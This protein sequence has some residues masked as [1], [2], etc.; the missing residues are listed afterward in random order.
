M[1]ENPTPKRESER[2]PQCKTRS[3]IDVDCTLNLTFLSLTPFLS[4]PA[5]GEEALLQLADRG[6]GR[7]ERRVRVIVVRKVEEKG[8]KSPSNSLTAAG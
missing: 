3:E 1:S 6:Q 5:R 7:G 4:L 2:G 8:K